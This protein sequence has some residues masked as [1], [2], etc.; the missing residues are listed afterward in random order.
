MRSQTVIAI[1]AYVLSIWAFLLSPYKRDD[2]LEGL[3]LVEFGIAPF[4]VPLIS[5][6]ML[7]HWPVFI[8][9]LSGGLLLALAVIWK[10]V[11]GVLLYFSLLAFFVSGVESIWLIASV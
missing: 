4:L 6:L 7:F 2:L 5:L 3:S 9:F 10:P 8:P 1:V 11:R